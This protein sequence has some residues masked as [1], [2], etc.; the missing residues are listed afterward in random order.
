MILTKI[1]S[2]VFINILI[3]LIIFTSY[4]NFVLLHLKKLNETSIFKD[5]IPHNYFFSLFFISFLEYVGKS[6]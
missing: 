4:F 1:S 5:H 2:T 3:M 6:N